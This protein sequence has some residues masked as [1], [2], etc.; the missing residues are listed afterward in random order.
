MTLTLSYKVL[1]SESGKGHRDNNALFPKP[2]A[3]TSNSA[4]PAKVELQEPG[5][6]ATVSGGQTILKW[7]EA[8]GV[9]SYHVQVATDPNFKWLTVDAPLHKG[10]TYQVQNLEA[11]KHYYWRV[12]ATK[13]SN[14][15]GSSKGPYSNSMFETK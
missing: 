6:A 5:F 10:T 13:Q 8:T 12:S 1:A 9:E 4:M 2:Q 3:K 15:P 7:S 14:W 11:G